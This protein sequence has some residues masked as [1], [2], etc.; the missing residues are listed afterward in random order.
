MSA[1]VMGVVLVKGEL[2]QIPKYGLTLE[3]VEYAFGV[4]ELVKSLRKIGALRPAQ[5]VGRSMVFDAGHLAEVWA[6]FTAGEYTARLLQLE[7]KGARKP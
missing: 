1:A 6:R 5:M 4:A 3:E 2:R 7:G